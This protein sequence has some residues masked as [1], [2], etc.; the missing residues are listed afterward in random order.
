MPTRVKGCSNYRF[1]RYV[2]GV[3]RIQNSSGTSKLKEFRRRDGILSKLIESGSLETLRLLKEGRLSIRE[4]LDADRQGR[5]GEA[6]D[7]LRLHRPL[8]DAVNEWLPA[9]A[10]EKRSRDRYRVSWNKFLKTARSARQLG[11]TP[12]VM[13]LAHVDFV[14]LQQAWSGSG[15]D[16]NRARAM[17]SRFLT[18]LMGHV[19]NPFRL[20]VMGGYPHG[21]E[22]QGVL[23][24]ATAE[25]FWRIVEAAPGHVRASFVAMMVLGTGPGEYLGI[26][27]E[28]LSE[29][30]HTVVVNGQKTAYRQRTIAVDER[31]WVWIVAAVPSNVQYKWLN[32]YWNR[33]CR[34]AKVKNLRMYDLRHMSAQFAGDRGASDRD[35]TVHLGHSNPKMSHR[36]SR[37]RISRQVATHIADSLGGQHVSVVA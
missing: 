30:Q 31:L 11:V 6:T 2:K 9:S 19:F 35:L 18:R 37:R 26:R 16:W 10:P 33:A 24:E 8:I 13:D 34:K 27:R 36:Y 20:R 3:G 32:K 25:D 23:P 7:Q 17:I 4:L 21:K 1:D 5:L 28:D 12:A 14:R 29:D 22:S 15:S